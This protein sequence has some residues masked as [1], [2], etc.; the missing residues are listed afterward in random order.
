M[1]NTSKTTQFRQLS[2]ELF[3]TLLKILALNITPKKLKESALNF[4]WYV[5]IAILFGQLSA[6]ITLSSI[7][8]KGGDVAAAIN[9]QVANGNFLTFS[10][11]LL[12]SSGYFM[13]REFHSQQEIKARLLKSPLILISTLLLFAGTWI[14]NDLTNQSRTEI[15]SQQNTFHWIIYTGCII[16]SILWW[17]IEEW[18]G[19][20][21]DLQ[22]EIN[23]NSANATEKSKSN[24]Q[25]SRTGVEL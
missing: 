7:A 9:A 23:S 18:Q 1:E 8:W 6:I 24:N 13:I 2:A 15:T 10:V 3:P 4:V 17:S 22:D 5:S 16:A 25:E 19:T 14:S 12:A 21:G 11:T 20:V